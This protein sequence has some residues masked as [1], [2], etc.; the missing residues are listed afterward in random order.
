MNPLRRSRLLASGAALSLLLAATP[1]RADEWL[2]PDKALHFAA[3]AGIASGAFLLGE[4]VLDEPASRAALAANLA[5]VAGIGK[6]LYD[7]TGRGDPSLKDLTWDVIGTV[8]GLALG[9][10][11][12][13]L[14]HHGLL[15]GGLRLSF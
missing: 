3:T 5:L 8:A 9:V 12:E 4:L 15:R 10:L 13:R 1:A 7:L 6:E 11:L 14:L 2:G